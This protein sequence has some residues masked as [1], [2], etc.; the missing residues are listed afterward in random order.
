MTSIF[1]LLSIL[2][3]QPKSSLAEPFLKG[4]YYT[5]DGKRVEG[6]IKFGRATFSAFGSKP[7][8]IKFK[9]N[10][11]SSTVKLTAEDISAF[12]IE[13]D[14]FAIVQNIK[15][16]S[17]HGEYARDFAQV[18]EVGR[19]NLFVHKSSSSDGK[20]SYDHDK[21]VISKD[22]KVFLGIWNINKQREEISEY[23]SER[24]DLLAKILD[25]KDETPIPMLVKEF[26][27]DARP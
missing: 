18:I 6:L 2:T 4:H 17:I 12:V 25:K 5:N 27:K 1:I 21:F 16:N 22:N 24:P 14:S 13:K 26:N 15:I 8:N 7:S 10:S 9:A 23:F 11:S 3:L 19:I 20:F